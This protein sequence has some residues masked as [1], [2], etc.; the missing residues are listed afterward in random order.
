[1]Q[2]I[3]RRIDYGRSA[4]HRSRPAWGGVA[5]ADTEGL[6]DGEA[7]ELEIPTG[8]VLVVIDPLSRML[9]GNHDS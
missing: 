6:P 2:R 7:A 3:T 4:D 5:P 9:G 8:T 1:M